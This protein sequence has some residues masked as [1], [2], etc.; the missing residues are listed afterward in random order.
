MVRYQGATVGKFVS[1]E[2]ADLQ[3][4]TAKEIELDEFK[5]FQRFRALR[6]SQSEKQLQK[7]KEWDWVSVHTDQKEDSIEGEKES[8]PRGKSLSK[9]AKDADQLSNAK[10]TY[11]KQEKPPEV[12]EAKKYNQAFKNINFRSLFTDDINETPIPKGFK[13]PRVPL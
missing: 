11:K 9:D 12:I 2:G 7:E 3:G 1:N 13:G 4:K 6:K 5:A 10:N 8:S